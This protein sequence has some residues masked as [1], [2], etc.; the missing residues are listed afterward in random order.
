MALP[1]FSILAH[2]VANL[3]I[4]EFATHVVSFV[5][6]SHVTQPYEFSPK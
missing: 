2:T 3:H 6:P 5:A 4:G 1:F